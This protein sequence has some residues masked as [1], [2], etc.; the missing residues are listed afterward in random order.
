MRELTHYPADLA[1]MTVAQLV[2]LP[3]RDFIESEVSISAQI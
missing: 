3:I 1:S 2:S